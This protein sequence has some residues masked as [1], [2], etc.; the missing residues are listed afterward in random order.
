M[1]VFARL[2]WIERQLQEN[3]RCH[4]VDGCALRPGTIKVKVVLDPPGQVLGGEFV[5]QHLIQQVRRLQ[6]LVRQYVATD[7]GHKHSDGRSEIGIWIEARALRVRNQPPVDDDDDSSG[8][9]G[10]GAMKDG[11][12]KSSSGPHAGHKRPQGRSA[13]GVRAVTPPPKQSRLNNRALEF[14]AS[15]PPP[16]QPRCKEL[17]WRPKATVIASDASRLLVLDTLIPPFPF[18]LSGD[19]VPFQTA[20][21]A[22]DTIKAMAA[23]FSART[24][25]REAACSQKELLSMHDADLQGMMM[26]RRESRARY[27]QGII[28][29]GGFP[30][31]S[32]DPLLPPVFAEIQQDVLQLFYNIL[33]EASL[34]SPGG[35]LS[36][37]EAAAFGIVQDC[38]FDEVANTFRRGTRDRTTYPRELLAVIRRAQE[39]YR[40]FVRSA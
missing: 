10:D 2:S 24:C 33:Q 1:P 22:A 30:A 32:V 36:R 39:V 34:V 31:G 38:I 28:G 5:K 40:Q 13:G 15:A 6:Q 4:I 17:A 14:S 21:Q 27:I 25:M 26:R 3:R 12:G 35:R 29:R 11:S 7:R 8:H 9:H 18:Q 37:D 20:H 16:K 23:T 19:A